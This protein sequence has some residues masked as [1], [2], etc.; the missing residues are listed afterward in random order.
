MACA[1][2]IPRNNEERQTS[3]PENQCRE[4]EDNNRLGKIRDLYKKR[5]MR[6]SFHAKAS[7]IKDENGKDLADIGEIRSS[8]GE[9]TKALY[10]ND[11]NV[12]DN[13]S[14]TVDDLEPDI[15]EREVTRALRSIANSSKAHVPDGVPVELF[16]ILKEDANK[17]LHPICQKIWKTQQ[18]PSDWTRSIWIPGKAQLY[19]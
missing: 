10:K 11:L 1:C 7:R 17:V 13:H 16:K 4:V 5:G 9:H 12:I 3:F 15:L 18:W 19:I 8:W 2:R 6:E 14:D